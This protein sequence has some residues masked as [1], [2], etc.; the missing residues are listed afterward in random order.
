MDKG[1]EVYV[2]NISSGLPPDAELLNTFHFL[3]LAS[4]L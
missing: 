2:P 4:I 3:L 1:L